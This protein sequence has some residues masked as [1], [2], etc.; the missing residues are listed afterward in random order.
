M[1][2]LQRLAQSKPMPVPFKEKV[3]SNGSGG[4]YW[5][6]ESM[7]EE[8]ANREEM[9]LTRRHNRPW[10][11]QGSGTWG[12]V[13][14]NHEDEKEANEVL[15]YTRDKGEYQLAKR[16]LDMQLSGNPCP[17]AP[18]IIEA[19]KVPGSSSY[20]IIREYAR[21]LEDRTSEYDNEL[22]TATGE[23]LD[24]YSDEYNVLKNELLSCLKEWYLT[25]WD[26]SDNNL[27]WS[28]DYL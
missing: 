2:W 24:R 26:S 25:T 21:P 11:Y 1:N 19:R 10:A 23:R 16:L 3:P 22:L 5:I 17:C 6:D 4:I 14:R 20:R 12:L 18:K 28:T 27:G 15:K 7:P 13:Y 9:E 8:S